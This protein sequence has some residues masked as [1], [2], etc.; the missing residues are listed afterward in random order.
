VSYWEEG[1]S[2]PQKD[3]VHVLADL[4]GTGSHCAE[5]LRARHP[6]ASDPTNSI[7]L[8]SLTQARGALVQALREV[9]FAL[10]TINKR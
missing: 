5:Y 1:R 3:R 6:G 9:D 8:R 2:R 4:F 7:A 10:A